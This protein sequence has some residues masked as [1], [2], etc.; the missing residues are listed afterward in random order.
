MQKSKDIVG[1]TTITLDFA[2]VQA[3]LLLGIE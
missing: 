3:A 1:L 2:A